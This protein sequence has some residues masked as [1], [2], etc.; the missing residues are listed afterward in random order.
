VAEPEDD[1][2]AD[3]DENVGSGSV[4]LT[5]GGQSGPVIGTHEYVMHFP[6]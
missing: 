4:G 5:H 2:A 1:E 6:S 3:V